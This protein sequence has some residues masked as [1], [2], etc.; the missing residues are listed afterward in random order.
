MSYIA[1][2]SSSVNSTTVFFLSVLPPSSDSEVHHDRGGLEPRGRRFRE[3]DVTF[4]GVFVLG[5]PLFGVMVGA[6][7][8]SHSELDSCGSY[9]DPEAA[10]SSETTGEG[11]AFLLVGG[12]FSLVGFSFATSPSEVYPFSFLGG[13]GLFLF[14]YVLFFVSLVGYSFC[15]HRSRR[16]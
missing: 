6:S 11:G 2:N 16:H 14:L 4:D 9:S 7:L 8:S 1:F 13:C 3:E 5:R 12:P 15:P 10:P